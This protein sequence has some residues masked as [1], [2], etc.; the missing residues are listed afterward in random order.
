MQGVYMQALEQQAYIRHLDIH[1]TDIR[2]GFVD[3]DLLKGDF[4]YPLMLNSDKVARDIVE[5]ICQKK[6][7]KVIDWKWNLLTGLWR[8]LPNCLWRRMKL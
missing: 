7:I 2:P 1:F 3:T 5:A 6:H 8:M 4:S